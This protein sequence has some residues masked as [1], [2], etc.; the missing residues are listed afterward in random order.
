MNPLGFTFWLIVVVLTAWGVDRLARSLIKPKV[1]N[2]VLLPGT[3]VAQVGHILGL[4]LTGADISGAFPSHGGKSMDTS[5]TNS[6][7]RRLPVVGPLILGLLPL[8]ACATG[9]YVLCRRLGGPIVGRIA[10]LSSGPALPSSISGVWQMLRDQITLMESLVS[11]AASS[12]FTRWQTW[13]FG[14]VLTCLLVR[15][16]P[17]PG[18][19]RGALG[20]IVVL[21][22]AVAAAEQI[23]G[24]TGFAVH[25]MWTVLHFCVGTSLALLLA[26]LLV[27]GTIGLAQTLRRGA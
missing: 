25:E 1:L 24:R 10:A 13:V 18:N 27:R 21:G 3:L 4:L 6:K 16:A 22:L 23:L 11:A 17:S 5:P 2:A 7:R 8:L 9:I 12:D 26:L 20:G 19:V 14:Y 15:A